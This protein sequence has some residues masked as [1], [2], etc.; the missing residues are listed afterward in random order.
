MCFKLPKRA[1]RNFA[2]RRG[3]LV[4]LAGA[5][6]FAIAVPAQEP[7]VL[8]NELLASNGA[9]LV[10]EDGDFEDWIELHNPT[11]VVINLQGY[12]L[13]DDPEKPDKWS[14]P[15]VSIEPDGFLLVWASGKDRREPS[16]WPFPKPLKLAFASAG[17]DDGNFAKL[18]VNGEDKSLNLRGINIVRLSTQGV[19]LESTRF[20]TYESTTASQDL[21]HYL[22]GLADN[23]I[24]LL[25]IKDEATMSL[26]HAARLVLSD[27]G[28]E[29]IDRV[30]ESDS[31]GMII[32]VGQGKLAEAYTPR[33][34]GAASASI[35]SAATLHTNFKLNKAGES[36]AL[37]TP[38]GSLA[39]VVDFGKQVRDV[40]YGRSPDGGSRWCLFDDPTPNLPNDTVCAEGVSQAPQFSLEGGFYEHPLTLALSSSSVAQIHYTLDGSEP[41]LDSQ[42]Y[43]APLDLTRTQV[44]RARAYESGMISSPIVTHVYLIDETVHLPTLSL[45]T[46]P[47]NLWDERSGIY[48]E[49]VFPNHPNYMQRGQD[50]ERPVS[51]EFFEADR[52]PGFSLDAGIRIH[53]GTTREFPKK[54]F[55]L[56]FRDQYGRTPLKY[57]LFPERSGAHFK[58]LV[59]RNVGNDGAGALPHLRDPLMHVLWGEEGGLVSAKRSV[60]VFLNGEPWGI[61]NLREHL[62]PDYVTTN[63]GITDMDFITKDRNVEAGDDAHWAATMTFFEEH[64]FAL[65]EVYAQAQRLIDVDNFTDY[66]VFGIYG[67]N[68]DIIGNLVRF[69]PRSEVG[70]WRWIMWDADLSFSLDAEETPLSHNTLAWYTRDDFRPDLGPAWFDGDFWQTLF[71]RKLLE[72]ECYRY[73]F[74]NR[75]SD[76]LNTTLSAEHV[77]EKI[78]FLSSIIEADMP[79][80]I[81][82]WQNEWGGSISE[83]QANVQELREFAVRRPGFLRQHIVEQFGLGGVA[84]LTIQPPSGKGFVRVNTV[85]PP[86][87]PWFGVYFQDVPIT[88]QATPAP[89]YAFAGW[90]D[91]ALPVEPTV[92]VSLTTQ[93]AVQAVFVPKTP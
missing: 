88:L 38:D 19:Y 8:I 1:V 56:Y 5:L 57:P 55:I 63:F 75:F 66:Q 62:S 50:W 60:F 77:D 64:D 26:T 7:L 12:T 11:S 86:S 85:Q 72:N 39:D 3:I 37:Y 27:L 6:L 40:S 47:E 34:Q 87:Y 79:R 65:D 90:S 2:L 23:Q 32:Q 36:L 69:R 78:D 31:W 28:S 24:V 68:L 42:R 35:A 41:T 51:V 44:V 20:D 83:W 93:Y 10:D 48:T 80:E 89:G 49:G 29:L 30:G 91:P 16:R 71:L 67:G 9:I 33:G 59:V 45:V 73:H 46:D 25:A 4:A 92:T 53:G 15:D 58:S 82:L 22:E 61:Y 43:T 84:S 81:A 70:K 76:L 74:I 18:S 14:F 52:S 17:F 54:S 21:V 13:T